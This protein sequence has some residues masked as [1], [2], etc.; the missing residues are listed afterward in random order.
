LRNVAEKLNA[1]LHNVKFA[2]DGLREREFAG[3]ASTHDLDLG[4]ERVL[5]GAF[6]K[7]LRVHRERG[8]LPAMCW[9]HQPDKIPGKWLDMREDRDGLSVR[10][11][12]APTP[13]GDEARELLKMG[14][15]AGL[16]IGYQPVVTGFDASGARL[17]KEV[18]LYEVSLV[19]L[20]MNPAARVSSVKQQINITSIRDWERTLHYGVGLSSRAAVRAASKTWP[21]IARELNGTA[22]DIE[23]ATRDTE[24]NLVITKLRTLAARIRG[25]T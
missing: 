23:S 15:L 17:L 14:A 6:E 22:A 11:M 12:L 7:S 8:T 16:S 10:G 19:S 4:N 5:P 25:I 13:L 20:P 2:G 18:D 21:T 24:W 1:P 3:L 9:M